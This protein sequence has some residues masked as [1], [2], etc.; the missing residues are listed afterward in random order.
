MGYPAADAAPDSTDR[1][2]DRILAKDTRTFVDFDLYNVANAS[3]VL[4]VNNSYGAWLTQ[5]SILDARLF[6]VAVR[7]EF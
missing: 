4:R 3:Q 5:L 7:F 6:K 1:A 2:A